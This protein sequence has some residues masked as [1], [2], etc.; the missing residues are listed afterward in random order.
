M[1][2]IVVG[3]EKGG[4]GKSTIAFNLAAYLA[5][6]G[7]VLLVDTDTQR[8]SLKWD[9]ARQEMGLD[10]VFD[11]I[12]MT[13]KPASFI[14]EQ[15]SKYDAVIV[16]VG[17]RDYEAL[18]NFAKV[19]DLVIAPTKVGQG[20]LE[21]TVDFSQA[22]K[23]FH[24]KH[25]NNKIPMAFVVNAVPGPWNSSEGDDAASV[26]RDAVSTGEVLKTIIRDRRVWRDAHRL[27]K[28]I[29]EMPWGQSEKA[30]K[31][32]TSSMNEAFSVM[33][34]GGSK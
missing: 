21:S 28:T 26:L 25:K 22:M 7:R 16:D 1:S 18:G 3:A 17:A 11:A 4:V 13:V 9:E 24:G 23:S 8:T 5:K 30:I 27:G 10:K 34:M 33:K 14:V 32:F 20:D 15:A 19:A 2:V 6:T 31:E 12:G 29:F